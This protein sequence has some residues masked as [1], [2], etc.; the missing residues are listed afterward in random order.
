[1]SEGWPR[2]CP[3]LSRPPASAISAGSFPHTPISGWWFL[4]FCVV[5]PEPP[6]LVS[7]DFH[8]YLSVP[9]LHELK[10][11][12][13]SHSSGHLQNLARCPVNPGGMEEKLN[14][15]KGMRWGPQ[16]P[17]M[18]TGQG[19]RHRLT[20]PL[21]PKCISASAWR[22]GGASSSGQRRAGFPSVHRVD[23]A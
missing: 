9:S 1:M 16:P 15:Q 18:F 21:H 14:A 23:R 20:S 6:G 5:C 22:E 7:T 12:A 17:E 3:S 4:S 11:G 2:P 13:P 10:G 19:G 8:S